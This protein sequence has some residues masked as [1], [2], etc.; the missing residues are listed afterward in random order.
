MNT[1]IIGAIEYLSIADGYNSLD[2]IV[3]TAPVRILRAEIMN[4]GKFLIMFTGDVAS[5]EM[6]MDAGI[7]TGRAS[8]FDHILITSLSSQVIPALGSQDKPRE[9]DAVGIV[10]STSV[11]GAIDAA[12]RAAKEADISIISIRA[13]NETGGRGILTI[14][15][16]IG[17]VQPAMDAA[18]SALK[19][20]DRLYRDVIIP[21][22]HPDFKGF[23]SGN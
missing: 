12:D 13:G 5:V 18:L 7:E 10:E 4:P 2:A 11:P 23:I 15:G 6:S 16:P 9:I 21:G 19:A 14:S 3:K 17:D 8:V 20:R 22:P 1:D